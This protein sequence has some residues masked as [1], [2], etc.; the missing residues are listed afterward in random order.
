MGVAQRKMVNPRRI[1]HRRVKGWKK[2]QGAI[3]VH[4]SGKREYW[5]WAHNPFVIGR[6]GTREEVIALFVAKYEHDAVF[7]ERVRRELAEGSVLLLQVGRGL[8]R[9]CAPGVG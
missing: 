6:D 4:R 8:S 9:R 2:P 1:Q 3:C 7:R 5:H